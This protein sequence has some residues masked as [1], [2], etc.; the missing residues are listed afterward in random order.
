MREL[1][2]R[3]LDSLDNF[4]AGQILTTHERLKVGIYHQQVG[5]TW[6][7]LPHAQLKTVYREAKD[8]GRPIS[9]LNL[10]PSIV[11]V[12]RNVFDISTLWLSNVVCFDDDSV[13]E[14]AVV[15]D[16]K[17]HPARGMFSLI[18][19]KDEMIRALQNGYIEII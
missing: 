10:M 8:V 7:H 13:V 9:K 12:D 4:S 5:V 19:S 14:N 16:T 17:L 6:H 1:Q 15:F 3:L 2:E 11:C 18:A